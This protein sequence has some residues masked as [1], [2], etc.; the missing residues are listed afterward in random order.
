MASKKYD[1]LVTLRSNTAVIANIISLLLLAIAFVIF[2]YLGFRFIDISASSNAWKSFAV[3]AFIA[4]W[5]IIRLLSVKKSYFRFAL[6]VAGVY[7]IFSP[8]LFSWI[9][10]LYIIAG[11]LEKQ[12][13]IPQ[14]L[15]FD[16]DGITT[17]SIIPKHYNWDDLT[18]VL[19]KDNLLTIDFKT[20]RL[21]QKEL[22]NAISKE[23]ETEF[24]TFCLSCLRKA[25]VLI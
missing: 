22:Q 19:I 15:G 2:I 7:F 11:L 20:N 12:A 18:N 10:I 8:V 14:E 25:N 3:A 13:K 9:G 1:Y 5:V 21:Y 24:N 4:V 17:N 16:E 23:L 6:L